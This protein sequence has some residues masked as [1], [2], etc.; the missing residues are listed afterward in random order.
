M[1]TSIKKIDCSYNLEDNRIIDKLAGVLCFEEPEMIKKSKEF[2]NDWF[3]NKIEGD[4]ITI[5]TEKTNK[6]N[7]QSLIGVVRFWKTPYCN[8]KWLIE[9]LEV[10]ATERRKG[11]G[12]TMV[13]YGLDILRKSGIEKIS[14]HIRNTNI[15]SIRLHK[16]LG[17]VK[18]SLGAIDSFG[19]FNENID[20][21]IL[22]LKETW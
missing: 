20:E 7:K 18:V 3:S 22:L 15:P 2:W 12:R 13:K 5:V 19:E 1:K 10:I 17:F 8:N 11:I 4:K 9:G 16:S 21:Y 6:D 14:V